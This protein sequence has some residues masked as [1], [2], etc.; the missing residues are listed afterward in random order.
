MAMAA[1]VTA[2]ANADDAVTASFGDLSV[3]VGCTGQTGGATYSVSY[4]GKQVL[5]PSPLGF[6][7]DIADFTSGLTLVRSET[8]PYNDNYTV[9]RT[10]HEDPVKVDATRLDCTFKNQKGQEMTVEFMISANDVAYRYNIPVIDKRAAIR[11]LDEKSSF[12]FP[13]GTL[14]YL[15]PQSDAMIG[16][17][18]SKPSYEEEY[19]LGRPLDEK[20]QYGHGYTFPAL[21][22]VEP[23]SLW[24]L[25]SETGVDSR[26]CASRLGDFNGSGYEIEFPMPEENN[27]N[28]TVEPAFA[29]PGSTPW[30]TVTVGTSLKPIVETTVTW[31]YVEPRFEPSVDYK[32]GRSTWAWI[33]WQ[34]PSSNYADLKTF[35]DFAADMGYEYSLIDANWDKNPGREKTAELMNYAVSRGVNPF[36]WYSSSGWWNDIVQTPTNIMC[37]PILRKKE[38]KWL[39]DNGAK[40]I[41]VDFFGGDKQETMR[42]Y[43]AIL[44]DANDYGLTVIFHGCTLPRG[45]E[46][47]Y[48]NYVGSEAVLAS[49]NLIFQQHFCDEEAVNATTHPFIRNTVGCMEYGGSFMNRRLNRGNDGGTTRR[50]GDVFQLATTVLYQNPIQNF[51][52]APNNLTDAPEVCIDYLKNVPTTWNE[53]RYVDGC[54]GQYAVIARRAGERWYVAGVNATDKPVE[55]F[56]QLPEKFNGEVTLYA[57][58]FTPEAKKTIRKETKQ[59]V[60]HV[61]SA[62]DFTP[63]VSKPK[64]GKDNMIRL[65]IQPSGGV[66]AVF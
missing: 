38:M 4:L 20:S 37:D 1:T 28:G 48:P 29:L 22:N 23:D 42:I 54:P 26:Y 12:R 9:T 7:S 10:K 50:T 21:F 59:G 47:M 34:D 11:I 57:D 8:A 66:V 32:P 6:N 35:I 65:T 14:S 36:I 62:D 56:V 5:L 63:V 2:P 61:Y 53:T 16:W 30:R 64:P 60:T 15:T 55:T 49:E 19:R 51:A 52:L 45:W 13:A 39:R 58:T 24:V 33:L 43:E 41:K 25:V 18:R 17:K 46:R 40:G 44:S 3:T 31:N 27:G